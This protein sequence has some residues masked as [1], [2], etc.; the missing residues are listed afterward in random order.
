MRI[1]I[2]MDIP[3]HIAVTG[4]LAKLDWISQLDRQASLG[5]DERRPVKK[6]CLR[7]MC[8]G[9]LRGGHCAMDE[10]QR[11]LDNRNG[12]D[13]IADRKRV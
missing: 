5:N 6:G 1:A 2:G 10:A 4:G 8:V 9:E 3:M 7:W 13:Y 12:G 11:Q